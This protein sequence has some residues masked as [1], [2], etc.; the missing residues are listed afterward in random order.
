MA[1]EKKVVLPDKRTMNLYYKPDKTTRPATIALYVLFALSL[2][3]A[4]AKFGVY[5]LLVKL[6][7]TQSELARTQATEQQYAL[8]LT[9]YDEVLHQYHLYN[10]TDDELRTT[11]RMEILDMLESL[12][13]SRADVVSY[14]IAGPTVSFQMSGI[15]LGESAEIIR[16][17]RE[18]PLVAT[19]SVN[20]A[21]TNED[22][23]D[24]TTPDDPNM[25]VT[26]TVTITLAK[27][28]G[29]Q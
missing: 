22:A 19:A 16:S 13:R 3:L 1:K 11:D 29:I 8:Q 21:A 7:E 17:L 12:V 26:A 25:P 4:V 5:D 10:A 18:N 28:A 27:E 6:D 14:S 2:L 15:T 20:T 23:G 24:A 9:D